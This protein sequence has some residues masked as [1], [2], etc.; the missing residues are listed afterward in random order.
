MAWEDAWHW[1]DADRAAA[2]V[3]RVLRPGGALALVWRW[4]EDAGAGWARLVGARLAAF[5]AST[6]GSSASRAARA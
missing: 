3:H 4:P 6:P 5:A 2:E 1:F